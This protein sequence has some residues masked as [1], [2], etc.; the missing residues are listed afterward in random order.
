M[1]NQLTPKQETFCLAYLET[2]NAS[3]AY[4]RAYNANK[5]KPATIN[6]NAKAL[7]DNNKIA[8]R[9]A[10]VVEK[11]AEKTG[12]SVER[13][14]LEIARV[15]YF[16]GRKIYNKDGGLKQPTEWDDDTAAAI[17][18]MGRTGPVPFDKNAALE[19]AMKYHGLYKN[20]NHQ[21]G[22]AAIRALMEAVG[23]DAAHFEVKP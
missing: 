20:D 13:T 18:H 19:K 1:K 12:L 10:L 9:I 11:A 15:A 4:R 22:D 14:L 3:E 8:A 17:S 21:Q 5:M 2:G 16:D 7:L 6:R 23:K